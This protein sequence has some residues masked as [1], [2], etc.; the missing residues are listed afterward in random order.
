MAAAMQRRR[1]MTPSGR[2]R[3]AFRLAA[4]VVSSLLLV[5]LAVL[6]YRGSDGNVAS[7]TDALVALSSA[8]IGALVLIVVASPSSD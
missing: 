4:I 5:V 6:F 3:W 7:G 2:Q 1:S 8:L